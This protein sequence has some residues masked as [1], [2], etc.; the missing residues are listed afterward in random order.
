MPTLVLSPRHTDDSTALWRA[1]IKAGWD[2]VRAQGW[3]LPKGIES[4]VI[5]GETMFV[6]WAAEEL[7]VTLMEPAAS[8]LPLM[9]WRL[10]LRQVWI[11]T[12]GQARAATA[13]VFVK[14]PERKS[15][16]AVVHRPGEILAPGF[17]DG[18][19][20]LMSGVVAFEAEIRCWVLDGR[21]VASAQYRGGQCDHGIAR[22]IAEESSRYGAPAA[23]VIDVGRL[24][25]G[26]WAVVEANPA[27]SSGIYGADP[28][29]VLTVVERATIPG[30][31]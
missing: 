15:F 24:N 18:E 21:A 27:S 4:P 23:V 25:T 17:D 20:A 1:A 3:Q 16:A 13:P 7:G 8:W 30:R 31:H 26:E 11:G 29:A 14:P 22:G 2:I 5:Y 10:R 28:E 6:D 19:T 12:L 9:P